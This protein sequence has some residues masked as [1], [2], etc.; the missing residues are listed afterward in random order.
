MNQ[1]GLEELL[2]E[3]VRRILAISDPQQI[4]LFGESVIESSSINLEIC[5][6]SHLF[7]L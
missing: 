5:L 3:I 1:D 7:F 4:V 6:N 2:E